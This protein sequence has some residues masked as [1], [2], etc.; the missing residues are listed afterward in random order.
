MSMETAFVA[1][2]TEWERRYR[3]EPTRFQSEQ[4]K[5]AAS[6]QSYGEACTPYFIQILNEISGGRAWDTIK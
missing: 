2:F 4:A 5:L 6:P 3:E 1:A